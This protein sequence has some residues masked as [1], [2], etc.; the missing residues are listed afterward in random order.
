MKNKKGPNKADKEK[1]GLLEKIHCSVNYLY[2]VPCHPKV[3]TSK[4]KNEEEIEL[5]FD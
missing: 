1:A 2:T 4:I 3:N 5:K